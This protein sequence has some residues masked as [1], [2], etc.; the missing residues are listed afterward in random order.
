M[1]FFYRWLAI[2]VYMLYCLLYVTPLPTLSL[3]LS[4]SAVQLG[5]DDDEWA[6]YEHAPTA[7]AL[8]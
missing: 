5:K 6:A 7:D 8:S 3:S 1:I 2:Y 4:F